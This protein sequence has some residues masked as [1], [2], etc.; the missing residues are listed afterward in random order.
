[1]S[2][3]PAPGAIILP[4]PEHPL[5]APLRLQRAMAGLAA[6]MAEQR[7][8]LEE[9]RHALGALKAAAGGLQGSLIAYDTAL[10]GLGQGVARLGAQ[11]RHLQAR[12]DTAGDG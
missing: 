7:A 3:L 10:G 6:A 1:M 8:A 2:A 12:C 9:F 5:P 11:A 4:F